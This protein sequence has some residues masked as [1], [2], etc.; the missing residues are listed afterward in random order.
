MWC[1]SRMS[2]ARHAILLAED[3]VMR[4]LTHGSRGTFRRDAE[5]SAA[6]DRRRRLPRPSR[7]RTTSTVCYGLR[8]EL[9]NTADI[10]ETNTLTEQ[11]DIRGECGPTREFVVADVFVTS[12]R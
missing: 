8:L 4:F 3:K 1:P 12:G 9:P 6:T 11:R 7:Q 10:I 2:F 5:G